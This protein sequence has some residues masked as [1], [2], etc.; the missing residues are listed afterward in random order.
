MLPRSVADVEEALA[1]LLEGVSVAGYAAGE[2][3]PAWTESPIPLTAAR[4]DGSLLSH[5]R[6][7][8]SVEVAQADAGGGGIDPS[9]RAHIMADVAVVYLYRLRARLEDRLADSRAAA[10]LAA[11]VVRGMLRP[12]T[13]PPGAEAVRGVTLTPTTI[14]R[15]GREVGGFM[16]VEVRFSAAFDLSL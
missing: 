7:S 10:R 14:Y 6:Y 16:P 12:A 8:V 1:A 2:P 9:G 13:L 5:L 4:P 3:A 11:D 15:P